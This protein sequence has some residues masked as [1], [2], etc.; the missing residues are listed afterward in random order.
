MC[1]A[2]PSLAPSPRMRMRKSPAPDAHLKKGFTPQRKTQRPRMVSVLILMNGS[3]IA[4]WSNN[5]FWV[6]RKSAFPTPQRTTCSCSL[7]RTWNLSVSGR[8]SSC[9][10]PWCRNSAM[11]GS[12]A[13]F[14][15][16][17]RKLLV[18]CFHT[19][20]IFFCFTRLFRSM[21]FWPPHT[22]FSKRHHKLMSIIVVGPLD[23]VGSSFS[24]ANIASAS[25]CARSFNFHPSISDAAKSLSRSRSYCRRVGLS[26]RV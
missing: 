4:D 17:M 7:A 21:V 23:T 13:P 24:F 1:K 12:G 20:E 26:V 14:G 10:S 18:S 3:S 15:T 6:T 16:S 2:P 8:K 5:T 9:W 11:N 25:N 19:S 22:N